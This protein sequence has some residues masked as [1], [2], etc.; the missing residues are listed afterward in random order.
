MIGL[1]A[2]IGIALDVVAIFV[3]ILIDILTVHLVVAG[4]WRGIFG[5]EKT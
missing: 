2:S 4:R 3:A 5:Y 1:P